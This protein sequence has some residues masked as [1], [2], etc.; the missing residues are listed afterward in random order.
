M[1]LEIS[2]LSC[3]YGDIKVL[4]SLS[5]SAREGQVLALLGRNGAGKTTALKAIS[6]LI[7]S[8]GQVAL[9]GRRI[10]AVPPYKRV[11]EGLAF[12][13]E[14][15]RIFRQ[16]TVAENL[17]LGAYSLR[18]RPRELEPLV[19]EAYDRFPIL[20]DKADD[21]AGSLSGG[22]Q[23]MLA[24]AQALIRRPAVLLVDEPSAG[25]APAIVGEVYDVIGSLRDD[26]MTVLLVEQAVGWAASVADRVAVL[27]VGEKIYEGDPGTPE[28]EAAIRRIE[29]TAE[30]SPTG[31]D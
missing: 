24:I 30:P 22:Q 10:D 16:R 5:L 18:L 28:A 17:Q 9:G 14:G 23:Q 15:K 11:G 25:L 3:G 26:G 27:E 12:V 8:T 7:R 2:E 21:A 1:S 20:R 4:R 13:Q 6:G 19:S 31:R 29:L